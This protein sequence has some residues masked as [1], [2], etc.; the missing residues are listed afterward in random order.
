MRHVWNESRS[1]A[2]QMVAAWTKEDAVIRV[3]K[4]TRTLSLNVLAAIGFS[5]SFNFESSAPEQTGSAD[6]KFSYRDALQLVLDHAI[7]VMVVGRQHLLYSWLPAWIRRIGKAAD[8]FQTH[9]ETMLDDEMTS[10]NRGE[11]GTGTIMTSFVRAL[12]QHQQDSSKGMSAEEVFGNTFIINFAGHDTTANS[13]AFA[14]LLLGANP[15]VQE[16]MAEE[17]RQA[18]AGSTQDNWDYATLFPKLLRCRAVLVS[19]VSVKTRDLI[20]ISIQLETLRLYPPIMSLPKQTIDQAQELTAEGRTILV[21]PK[22]TIFGSVL[23]TH[24]YSEYWPDPL[25]WKP[26]RW[27]ER[28]A[29][30][31]E[32]IITPDRITYFPWS[33]GVQNCPGQKFSLVEFVVV[34]ATLVSEHRLRPVREPGESVGQMQE[35]LRSVANDCEAIMILRVK[36]ADQVRMNLEKV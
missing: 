4:D 26:S 36:D 9:M 5:K 8:D 29:S 35:R 11:K 6:E 17:V 13:F 24:T 27:I 1:Q 18:I 16:W 25:T 19:K 30:G 22:T 12:D 20:L 14:V 32:A 34:M 10:L 28:D 7:L 15:A 21:P 33:D 2:Q 31:Q 3:A 23:G